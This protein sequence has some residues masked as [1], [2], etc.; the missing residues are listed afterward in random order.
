MTN[1]ITPIERLDKIKKSL[2]LKRNTHTVYIPIT[3]HIYHDG[4]SFRVRFQKNK[5]K[6]SK[7]FSSFSD[8]FNY[9]NMSYM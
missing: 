4:L 2:F 8:A 6:Y 9:K 3:D 5:I 7:N 1:F